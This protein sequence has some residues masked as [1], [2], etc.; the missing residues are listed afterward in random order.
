MWLMVLDSQAF[1]AISG[2][3]GG[4]TG[5]RLVPGG[6]FEGVLMEGVQVDA[7]LQ[8]YSIAFRKLQI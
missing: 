8:G 2:A 3:I 1:W 7:R 6:C 4:A 5:F